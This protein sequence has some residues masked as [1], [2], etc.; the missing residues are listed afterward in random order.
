MDL[1]ICTKGEIVLCLKMCGFLLFSQFL[2]K[3]KTIGA[4]VNLLFFHVF[5]Q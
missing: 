2:S 3:L 1:I 5:I 4:I